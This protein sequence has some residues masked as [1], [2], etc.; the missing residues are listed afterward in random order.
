MQLHQFLHQ[1]QAD[2]AALV[3]AALR[4]CDP[5][6][7]LEQPAQRLGRDPGAGVAH[8][9]DGRSARDADADADFTDEGELEGVREQVEDDLLPHVAIDVDRLRKRRAVD[10]EPQPGFLAGRAEIAGELRSEGSEI[11]RLI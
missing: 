6:E 2:A 9:E 11:G 1:G 7:A 5:V 8:G 3:A 10:D 4:A